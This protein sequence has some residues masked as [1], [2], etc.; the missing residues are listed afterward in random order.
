M[1]DMQ[2]GGDFGIPVLDT[3]G[4]DNRFRSIYN[5]AICML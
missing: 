4:E 1:S 2:C 5:F 3:T